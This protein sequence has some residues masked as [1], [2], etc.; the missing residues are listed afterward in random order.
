MGKNISFS[1]SSAGIKEAL[2]EL[3]SYQKSIAEKNKRFVELLGEIGFEKASE[4]LATGSHRMPEKITLTKDIDV[5]GQKVTMKIIG[6]GTTFT[7]VWTDWAGNEHIGTVYP[8]HMMEF[9][10][11][12]GAINPSNDFG[13]TV[14]GRGT[15][16]EMGHYDHSDWYVNVGTKDE[17][18]VKHATAIPA[19]R[20]LYNAM[21]EMEKSVQKAAKEAFG[22]E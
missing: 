11:A 15:F 19:V 3:R 12:A 14:G 22:G 18:H 21:I 6:E 4:V 17:P 20:P 5:E 10:S 2:R 1:L 8:M 16:S 7:S 9:G 13:A